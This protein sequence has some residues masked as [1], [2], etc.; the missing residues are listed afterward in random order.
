M[1]RKLSHLLFRLARVQSKIDFESR[2]PR[3]D[4]RALLRLKLL[5]L[6]LKDRVAFVLKAA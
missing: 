1:R 2:N 5:R 3:P 4:W 6:R